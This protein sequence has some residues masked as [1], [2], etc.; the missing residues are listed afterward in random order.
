MNTHH[1]SRP[2]EALLLGGTQREEARVWNRQWPSR[3]SK[4][5]IRARCYKE[6]GWKRKKER[7][8]ERKRRALT[9]R[10]MMVVVL[11]AC[12]SAATATAAEVGDCGEGRKEKEKERERK[13]ERE[14][15]PPWKGSVGPEPN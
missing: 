7:E 11:V 4:S 6:E 10:E 13:R 1:K 9:R 5:G 14:T 2:S 15:A 8:R 12:A 3:K